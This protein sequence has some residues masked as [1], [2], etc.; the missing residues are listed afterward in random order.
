LT[1]LVVLTLRRLGLRC[2]RLMTVSGALLAFAAVLFALDHRF[3]D[4]T[5]GA[6]ALATGAVL[7]SGKSF[8]R[9]DDAAIHFESMRLARA[10]RNT[11]LACLR[12]NEWPLCE[13]ELYKL[14]RESQERLPCDQRKP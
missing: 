4:R 13:Q 3:S 6:L 2:L 1:Y 12:N 7:T 9:T 8:R 10:C 11:A 5:W 14:I